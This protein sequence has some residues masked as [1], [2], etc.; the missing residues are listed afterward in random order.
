MR[1]RMNY[2]NLGTWTL[3]YRI[4]IEI[5][6]NHILLWQFVCASLRTEELFIHNFQYFFTE[7]KATRLSPGQ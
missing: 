6:I 5:L 1:M 7:I 2:S 3:A 4:S